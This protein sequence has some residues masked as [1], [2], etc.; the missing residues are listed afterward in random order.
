M[1]SLPQLIKQTKQ[2]EEELD[3]DRNSV[4]N[5][6][7]FN[8]HKDARVTIFSK[9]ILVQRSIRLC[10]IFR[11]NHLTEPDWWKGL[12]ADINWSL[13]S[14][15]DSLEDPLGHYIDEFTDFSTVGYVHT[16]FSSIES[17]FRIFMR[18][19]DPNAC[20]KGTDD[21]INIYQ[22][23]LTK[24]TFGN[25]ICML[26]LLRLMRNTIHNNG[27]YYHRKNL[28]E[29]VRYNGKT[30]TFEL[31]KGV[32]YGDV[33]ELLQFQIMPDAKRMIAD[34]VN[35]K[36]ISSIPQIVDPFIKI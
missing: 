11:K 21:F 34:V 20:N 14:D 8:K 25:Y 7:A 1:I 26:H 16:L 33:W 29:I 35:T 28:K 17:S 31:G 12:S 22:W 13:P 32:E 5:R 18:A 27:V 15:H 3:M 36:D 6:Y 30:Y 10:F 2:I 9:V 19:L 4:L 23:L 24:L